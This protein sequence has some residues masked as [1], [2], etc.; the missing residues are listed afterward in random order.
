MTKA[1]II[2]MTKA[3][4]IEIPKA[5]IIKMTMLPKAKGMIISGGWRR[6]IIIKSR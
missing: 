2:K 5:L 3:L 6:W 4:T 1:L